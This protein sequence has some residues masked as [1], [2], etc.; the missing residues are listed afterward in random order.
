MKKMFTKRLC[1]YMLV[2]FVV[3]ITAI[4]IFESFV[5]QSNNTTQSRDKLEAVKEKLASNDEEILRLT[6]NLGENNLAKSRAF[7]DLL[8]SDPS[9]LD[10]KAKLNEICE[11]LMVNELHVIDEKGIITHSTVDAY[12]GFDMGSG[13]QSAAFLVITDDPSIEIVQ[14]PQENAAEGIIIQYIGVARKDAKGFVQVGIRPEILEETLKNTAIDVVLKDFEFG[15]KGYVFAIDKE[16]GNILA[17]PSESLIGTSA[18]SAGFDTKA[19]KGRIKVKGT[20]G[21]YVTEEYNGM[22]IG[23]F[24]PSSEYYE[25]RFS[26]TLVTAI[27]LCIVFLI[28]LLA[29]NRTVDKLIVKGINNIRLSM[30]QIADGDYSVMV[31]EAGNPELI[32]LSDSI[33][34]MVDSIRAN[35]SKN[36]LLL[37]KQKESMESNYAIIDNV[38]AACRNLRSA[39]TAT[40]NGAEKIT[41][42]TEQQRKSVADM[43]V[44]MDRLVKE[45][46]N[47]ADETIKVTSTTDKAVVEINRTKEHMKE[48]GESMN[49]ISEITMKIEKIIDEINSIA[50][51]TNLL[52]LNASIE[53]ARAGETGRGFA[54]VAT[55]IGELAARS[56]QAAKETNAL[57][58]SSIEAV[59]NGMEITESTMDGFGSTVTAIG[60]VEKEVEDIAQLVR[61][62]VHLVSEAVNELGKIARVVDTNIEISHNSRQISADMAHIT[63]QL[64]DFVRT[65]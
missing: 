48:L 59:T 31:K 50:E 25:A 30:R 62:N 45:L 38:K 12:I 6:T 26:Q 63:S 20:T 15:K 18:K 33:N 11:R 43:K 37:D 29:I 41:S 3:T 57:I 60:N 34:T 28:L 23:T 8:A 2:A 24:L 5:S 14:E 64:M 56:T 35:I 52:A 44:V 32:Q 7:A 51:Q 36:D 19:G 17:H 22:L 1:V 39:S 65:E 53:A 42:G 9:I 47:S 21:Y 40:L 55:Q 58:T 46:H 27:S 16:T 4:F 10:S 13:E 49:H 61:E 54:V